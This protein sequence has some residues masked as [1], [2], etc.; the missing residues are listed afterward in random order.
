MIDYRKLDP[1]L[2]FL[3]GKRLLLLGP[4]NERPM[5]ERIPDQIFDEKAATAAT[6]SLH[7]RSSKKLDSMTH[8]VKRG[9]IVDES[10]EHGPTSNFYGIQITELRIDSIN[11]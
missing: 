4:K 9:R 1:N 8:S 7:R 5:M 11:L 2:T 3:K 10:N 6:A